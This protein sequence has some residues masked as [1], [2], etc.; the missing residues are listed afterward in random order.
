MNFSREGQGSG[1]E[2]I[3]SDLRVQGLG[4]YKGFYRCSLQAL[5]G[6]YPARV[7]EGFQD[8]LK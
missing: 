4:C 6:F 3:S 8:G 2:A 5:R 7:L 1:K